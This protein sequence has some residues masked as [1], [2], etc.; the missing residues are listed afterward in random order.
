M[1][2]SQAAP[3]ASASPALAGLGPRIAAYLLDLLIALSV[4]LLVAI[5]MRVLR[6]VGVWTPGVGGDPVEIWR[7][8]GV[9]AKLLIVSAYVL[10]G[11]PVYYILFHASPWQATFG[12]RLLNIYVTNDA[13]SRIT[14]AR[15]F[16][17]CVA[18]WVFGWFGGSLASFLTIAT[19]PKKKVL[20]DFV[21]HTLVV[22]GRPVSTE[23]I[24][25]WRV[26][27]AFVV[28]LLL[29]PGDVPHSVLSFRFKV[30]LEC[31]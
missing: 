21:A 20:H 2:T 6:A 19:T 31:G 12:K 22:T 18:M 11:G 15:S 27:A 28:P 4:L 29:D 14:L 24:E 9:G 30:C 26:T 3:S 5:T 17:R 16:G 25:A 7:A 8:L 1:A 13:G 23:H 10:A